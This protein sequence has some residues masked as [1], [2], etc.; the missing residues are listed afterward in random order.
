MADVQHAKTK[1]VVTR[2]RRKPASA[3]SAAKRNGRRST[4]KA[5][6]HP[7]AAE[8]AERGKAARDDGAPV[9]DGRVPARA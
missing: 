2:A 5:V 9:R 4:P 6:P 1:A 8:R 3:A 7:T